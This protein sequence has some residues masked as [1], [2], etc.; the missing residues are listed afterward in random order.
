ME[1]IDVNEL[2]PESKVTYVFHTTK[3]LCRNNG[4]GDW[5]HDKD[6]VIHLVVSNMGYP[7][8]ESLV[9]G[10]EFDEA[11]MCIKNGVTG[12]AVT[13]FD[14]QFKEGEYDEA[15]NDPAAPYHKEHMAAMENEKRKC[16]V[17]GIDWDWYD[18]VL[19]QF[20]DTMMA[21]ENENKPECFIQKD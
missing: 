16:E 6:G 19:E 14:A 9:L 17:M 18:G 21:E 1:I 15:G 4:V 20:L 10:H 3:G 7:E 2:Y 12:E 8:L 13:A 5:F 11:T